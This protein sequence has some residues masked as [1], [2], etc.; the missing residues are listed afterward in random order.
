MSKKIK[1][2]KNKMTNKHNTRKP[3]EDRSNGKNNS[4]DS[5]RWWQGGLSPFFV[6]A[7]DMV[8]AGLFPTMQEASNY[9]KNTQMIDPELAEHVGLYGIPRRTGDNYVYSDLDIRGRYNPFGEK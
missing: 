8:D 4:L 1:L 2:R 9:M 6:A 5:S 3:D 7:T